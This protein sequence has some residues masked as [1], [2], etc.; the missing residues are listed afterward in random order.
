MAYNI[1]KKKIKIKLV[2]FSTEIIQFTIYIYVFI[3]YVLQCVWNEQTNPV[4]CIIAAKWDVFMPG[5][6]HISNTKLFGFGFNR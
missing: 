3:L 1:I 6:A 4:F 5:A 2:L